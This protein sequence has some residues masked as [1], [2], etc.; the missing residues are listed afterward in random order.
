MTAEEADKCLIS[1]EVARKI[2]NA[3]VC[4]TEEDNKNID[5]IAEHLA[6]IIAAKRAGISKLE[7][8]L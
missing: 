5:I 3:V 1:L 2:A 8:E 6:L 7:C 4:L